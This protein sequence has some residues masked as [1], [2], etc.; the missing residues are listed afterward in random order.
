[1]AHGLRSMTVYVDLKRRRVAS[2]S[3]LDADEVIYP[4]DY[5]PPPPKPD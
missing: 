5:K 4:P 2:F 1:M 3:P